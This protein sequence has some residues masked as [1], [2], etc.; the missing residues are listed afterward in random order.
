ML[1]QA[2]NKD[3]LL[4]RQASHAD[5]ARPFLYALAHS[6]LHDDGQVKNF[7]ELLERYSRGHYMMA[8]LEFSFDHPVEEVGRYVVPPPPPAWSSPRLWLRSCVHVKH[9]IG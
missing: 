8:P 6:H 1:F 5:T 3:K 7:L 9:D 2:R 4:E